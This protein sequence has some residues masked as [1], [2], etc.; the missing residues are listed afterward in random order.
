MSGRLEEIK[1]EHLECQGSDPDRRKLWHPRPPLQIGSLHYPCCP[2]TRRAS[3]TAVSPEAG[4]LPP[5]T[6]QRLLV[7][8]AHPAHSP[9]VSTNVTHATLFHMCCLE[10]VSFLYTQIARIPQPPPPSVSSP[11]TMRNRRERFRYAQGKLKRGESEGD[12]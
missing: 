11:V 2:E 6:A 9:P 10:P 1:R 7:T 8:S 3:A 4:C 12:G 5:R